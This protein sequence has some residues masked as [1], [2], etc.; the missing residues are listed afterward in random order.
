MGSP[1]GPRGSSPPGPA[2][3]WSYN[4]PASQLASRVPGS[5][6]NEH[7]SL[8]TLAVITGLSRTPSHTPRPSEGTG[9]EAQGPP[10]VSSP[11]AGSFWVGLCDGQKRAPGA[12]PQFGAC[13]TEASVAA[14]WS[15]G[16]HP[17]ALGWGGR[18]L[19]PWAPGTRFPTSGPGSVHRADPQHPGTVPASSLLSFPR[20]QLQAGGLGPPKLCP[21]QPCC[22]P[23]GR[24]V[25]RGASEGGLG[26]PCGTGLEA[27]PR[28]RPTLSFPAKQPVLGD[29]Q[30][31]GWGS[32]RCTPPGP[33]AA[34][35]LGPP[36]GCGLGT[37]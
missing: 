25:Q 1:W 9:R 37:G 21:I 22:P 27:A 29:A 12:P 35:P 23:A 13:V 18:H 14:V 6:G 2:P 31:L 7:P 3:S 33:L 24:R 19:G 32:A 30:S 20:W 34:K 4:S 26:S 10:P 28:P 15:L 8:L 11:S 5:R 17:W 16:L 36:G